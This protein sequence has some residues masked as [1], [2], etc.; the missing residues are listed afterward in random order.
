MKIKLDQVCTVCDKKALS[1]LYNLQYEQSIYHVARC[2]N[3]NLIQTLG[4]QNT[5]SPDYVGL[6]SISF[7]GDQLWYEK[8]HKLGAYRQLNYLLTSLSNNKKTK[9]VL[10]VGCGIGTF[11]DFMNDEEYACFGYDLSS[12]HVKIASSLH[13][14]VRIAQDS[15]EYLSELSESNRKFD[16]ITLWDVFEHIRDPV[17]QLSMLS[18]HMG[19][20]SCLYISVPAGN[21]LMLKRTLKKLFGVNDDESYIPWEHVYYHTEKSLSYALNKA[22]LYPVKY[23]SVDCYTR[24][25]SV[26]EYSRRLLFK[27]LQLTGV[28]RPQLGVVA[29][30]K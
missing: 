22:G 15:N 21:F 19:E 6:E 1:T 27:L 28:Y 4:Q 8:S 13:S 5:L 25:P 9:S 14:K 11:L 29:K 17:E 18:N 16:L 30:L 10:D 12:A 7:E 23:I 26:L 24:A 2:S 20:S 3:C